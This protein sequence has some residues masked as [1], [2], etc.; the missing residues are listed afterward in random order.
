MTEQVKQHTI[1]VLEF[2]KYFQ[3]IDELTL[4]E[5]QERFLQYEDLLIEFVEKL[6]GDKEDIN[7]TLTTWWLYENVEKKFIQYSP[8]YPDGRFYIYVE[9]AEDFVNYMLN[10]KDR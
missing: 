10:E 5:I 2:L 7:G 6:L 1:K 4:K 3:D 9:K 8:L